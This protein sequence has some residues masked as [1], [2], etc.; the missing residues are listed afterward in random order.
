M[1]EELKSLHDLLEEDPEIVDNIRVLIEEQASQSLLGIFKDIHPA[2]IAEIINHLN[3]N[4]AKYAFSILDTETASEVI[5]EIDEHLREKILEDV[6]A[7]KIADIVDELDTDDATDIVGVLPDNVAE[8]VLEYI[9]PESSEDVK[10]LLKYRE[11]SAGG[12]MNSD[13]VCVT[14]E[15]TISD[16]IEEVRKQADNIDHIYYIFVTKTNNELIGFILL[17]SLLL[18]PLET[19]VS[20]ILEEDLITVHPEDDQELVAN[21]MKKYDL[22][23]IPVVNDNG[24]I[25]GRI[26]IDDIVD[27]IGEEAEEDIQKIAGLSEEEEI[28]DS[29]IKISRIR[30][31]WLFVALFGELISAVVLSSFQASI[32]KI[33]I[34][35][36]FI[37]VVMAM[38][39]SS[40]TQAAIVMVRRLSQY[41]IWFTNSYKKI[42]KEFIVGLLNG[43]MCGA[44]LIIATHFLFNAEI[45]FSIVLSISLLVIMIFA[46]VVGASIPLI[47]KKFG[48]DPA[49]A[50]GPFVTTMNDV[51]GLSI[52]LSI[53][54]VAFL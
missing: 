8:Q 17:K 29:S 51:F 38:G 12:I 30:L 6:T 1:A 25:L 23:S 14:E 27:V 49:V 10:E 34:A 37:P 2:D 5:T 28:S 42:F 50:T 7:E 36:F 26:T 21:L 47:L 19:K 13:F 11:D 4:D 40:G 54:T 48:A 15:A 45:K 18:H 39:G 33:L 20:E 3:V 32:E 52:Y 43:I 9:E 31:P 46:T 41:E 22:V 35:S 16:A 44:I 24:I 53:I